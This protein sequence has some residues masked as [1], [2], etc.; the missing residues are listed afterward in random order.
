MNKLLHVRGLPLPFE[1]VPY[2]SKNITILFHISNLM[3][4]L[5]NEWYVSSK[6]S[7]RFSSLLHCVRFCNKEFDIH[8]STSVTE[9][10]AYAVVTSSFGTNLESDVT[11]VLEQEYINLLFGSKFR[12]QHPYA[13]IKQIKR[14]IINFTV[15]PF[16]LIHWISHTN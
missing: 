1:R 9:N 15:S 13:E 7:N 2:T 6:V 11:E 3:R 16:I 10:C 14:Q 4:E 5:V 12:L 8:E